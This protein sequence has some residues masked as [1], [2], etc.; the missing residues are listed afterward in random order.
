M[1]ETITYK[2]TTVINRK[3][4]AEDL[5]NVI[6]LYSTELT[7]KEI[8]YRQAGYHVEINRYIKS[9]KATI[10]INSTAEVEIPEFNELSTNLEINTALRN[11][12]WKSPRKHLN[13]MVQTDGLNWNRKGTVSLVNRG[14]LPYVDADLMAFFTEG[15]AIE[16]GEVAKLGVQIQDVGFGW[17]APLDDVLIYANVVKEVTIVNTSD[18]LEQIAGLDLQDF[19]LSLLEKANAAE[20]RT[21]LGLS[22]PVVIAQRVSDL[23]LSNGVATEINY[24]SEILDLFGTWDGTTFTCSEAG[25]YTINF[26]CHLMSTAGTVTAGDHSI[27]IILN[28]TSY[29]FQRSIHSTGT[30]SVFISGQITVQL[31]VGDTIKSR[32]TANFTGSTATKLAGATTPTTLRIVKDK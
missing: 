7:N 19:G 2:N 6:E 23:T 27:A 13:L 26:N 3:L 17:I 32:C 31:N 4:K 16:A 15:L 10:D 30:A 21:L 11:L 18:N 5:Q 29:S 14:D 20:I 25:I 22:V 28:S 8:A 1:F 24:T 9:F 12:E